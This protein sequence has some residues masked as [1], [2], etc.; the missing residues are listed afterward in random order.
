MCSGLLFSSVNGRVRAQSVG[1]EEARKGCKEHIQSEIASI[2]AYW[3]RNGHVYL[4]ES[5]T[6]VTRSP[7]S[8]ESYLTV[9]DT[10]IR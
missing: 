9:V 4:G 1:M 7:V 5:G 10:L 6:K 8:S 2:S 3:I